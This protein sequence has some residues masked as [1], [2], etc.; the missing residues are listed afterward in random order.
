MLQSSNG[1]TQS[2]ARAPFFLASA[3]RLSLFGI[4]HSAFAVDGRAPFTAGDPPF[5]AGIDPRAA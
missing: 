5:T 1:E 3:L 2:G 4:R